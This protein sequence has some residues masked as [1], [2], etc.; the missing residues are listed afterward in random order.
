MEQIDTFIQLRIL[1]AALGEKPQA[2]WWD[3]S[4]LG[5]TGVR[6]LAYA[7]PRAPELAA[8]QGTVEA[9]RRVHDARIGATGVTHLFRQSYEVELL[10]IDHLKSAGTSL[11]N[12]ISNTH[13]EPEIYRSSLLAIAGAPELGHEGPI[14]I[15]NSN[16]LPDIASI[17]RMA[18]IYLG[19]LQNGKSAFPYFLGSL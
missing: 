7:F 15:G 11:R 2:G 16:E 14:Q 13:S 6:Y 18:A 1:V 4:F 8:I 3:S 10:I 17:K 19:A 9:A 12:Q 5:D